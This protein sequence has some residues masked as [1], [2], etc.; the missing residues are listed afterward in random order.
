[1]L[2]ATGSA[3]VQA[4][5]DALGARLRDATR[6]GDTLHLRE[7]ARFELV[8][9]GNA[10]AALKTALANWELHKEPADARIVLEAASAAGD[11]AAAEAVIAWVRST[12]LNDAALDA[13]L[14]KLGATT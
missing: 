5:A 14:A 8:L 9:L 12:G 3:D 4:A 13:P 7:Q 10:P 11:R 1:A 6:R 2:Q